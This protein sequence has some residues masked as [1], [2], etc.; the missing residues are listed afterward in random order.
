MLMNKRAG[1][2]RLS[3]QLSNVEGCRQ[4]W[5]TMYIP[6]FNTCTYTYLYV[7]IHVH[8]HI[9]VYMYIYS[10][11]HGPATITVSK[12]HTFISAC[13]HTYMYVYDYTYVYAKTYYKI[14]HT[15]LNMC[16]HGCTQQYQRHVCPSINACASSTHARTHAHPEYDSIHTSMDIKNQSY[17]HTY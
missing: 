15:E 9:Y 10:R 6:R 12:A 7:F 3:F 1:R 16:I 5:S 13:L 4:Y 11:H 2:R 14:M 17:K 8:V